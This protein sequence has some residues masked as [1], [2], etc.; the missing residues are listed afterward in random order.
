MNIPAIINQCMA[1]AFKGKIG[2]QREVFCVEFTRQKKESYHRIQNEITKQ[3]ETRDEKVTCHKGCSA[4]CVLYIEASIQESE[5]IVYFLYHKPDLLSGF[6]GR[7]D[8]WRYQ[9]R[10]LGDPFNRCEQILHEQREE[11]LTRNDQQTLLDTLRLY[12]IQDI[13]CPF[14]CDGICTIYEVRP[15]VCANHY[16]TTPSEG[17]Q[18]VNWCNPAFPDRP[19]IYMTDIDEIYDLSFYFNNLS[20]PVIGFVPT[21]V[22]SILT[23][24]LTYISKITGI[25]GLLHS[26]SEQ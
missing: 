11:E 19:M 10:Q 23:E 16:V 12:H 21:T 6:L 25:T 13:S 4:C 3:I 18:A 26:N 20:K 22:Y 9:M 14:L 2:R 5:A 15:Y 1:N 8:F 17:C 7:Y 24:G